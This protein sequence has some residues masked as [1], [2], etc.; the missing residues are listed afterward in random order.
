MGMRDSSNHQNNQTTSAFMGSF[1]H[2]LLKQNCCV[3]SVNPF[4]KRTA[5]NETVIRYFW[6]IGCMG[7][8]GQKK[9]FVRCQLK[10][11]KT[12]TLRRGANHPK[13]KSRSADISTLHFDEFWIGRNR[14]GWRKCEFQ[15]GTVWPT[16]CP[17][18]VV[19]FD[20]FLLDSQRIESVLHLSHKIWNEVVIWFRRHG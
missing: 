17:A 20:V 14:V 9:D 19:R 2:N 13:R 11:D 16:R 10:L 4:W 3:G 15:H 6:I 1:Y 8:S 5:Y 12:M 7:N 18:P